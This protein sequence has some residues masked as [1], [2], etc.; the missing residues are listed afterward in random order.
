MTVYFLFP[1]Y[2]VSNS[3]STS[4]AMK[5]DERPYLEAASGQ[6]VVACDLST[7]ESNTDVAP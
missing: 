2:R 4:G 5:S 6:A 3:R 1:Q 7:L